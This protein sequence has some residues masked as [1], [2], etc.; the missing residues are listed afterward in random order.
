MIKSTFYNLSEEKKNHLFDAARRELIRVTYHEASINRIVKDAGISRGSFY[1]YFDDKYDL[2]RALMSEFFSVIGK[3][4]EGVLKSSGGD[5]FTMFLTVFDTT[6]NY[7]A[8][9]DEMKLFK[10]L[11]QTLHMTVEPHES[12]A[13]FDE[14]NRTEGMRKIAEMVN[15]E[16][17]RFTEETDVLDL[18]DVL[19]AL[20]RKATIHAMAGKESVGEAR[21]GLERK[22]AIVKYGAL[23][24][25]AK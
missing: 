4:V 17:L 5:I 9:E 7:T 24:T 20:T 22:L 15:L 8:D 18:L 2:V 19:F 6:V 21:A 23:K 3:Q 12:K 13:M 14:V 11:F 16:N 10:S 25:E 1:T